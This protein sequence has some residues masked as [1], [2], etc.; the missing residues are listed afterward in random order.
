MHVWC[1]VFDSRRK[2]SFNT[3][4]REKFAA[5]AAAAAEIKKELNRPGSYI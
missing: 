3:Y 4:V 1:S 5:K 2:N